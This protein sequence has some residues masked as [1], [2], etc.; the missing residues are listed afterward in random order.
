MTTLTIVAQCLRYRDRGVNMAICGDEPKVYG[1]DKVITRTDGTMSQS[2]G[3]TFEKEAMLA[4]LSCAIE[5]EGS[6]QLT[7]GKR[8][9]GYIQLVP[10]VN[11][12][13]NDREY[14]VAYC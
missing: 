5:S 12:G 2:A 13:S 1:T 14:I 6:I 7:W 10:R 8:K 9:D 11:I 3:K 4:W